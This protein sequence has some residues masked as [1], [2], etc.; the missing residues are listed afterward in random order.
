M[1][2]VH[3]LILNAQKRF[4]EDPSKFNEIIILINESINIRKKI[5]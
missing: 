2:D 5:K 3:K 1:D 4:D